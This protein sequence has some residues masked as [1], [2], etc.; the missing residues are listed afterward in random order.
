MC[1]GKFNRKAPTPVTIALGVGVPLVPVPG[2]GLGLGSRPG[3]R[4]FRRLRCCTRAKKICGLENKHL[5]VY[6]LK[7]RRGGWWSGVFLCP[8][9]PVEVAQNL[10]L[11]KVTSWAARPTQ[12]HHPTAGAVP[13]PLG[14][15]QAEPGPCTSLLHSPTTSALLLHRLPLQAQPLG[16]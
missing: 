16:H 7:T 13:A 11:C 6:A 9:S 14:C 5:P 1:F 4:Q 15:V 12:H 10:P 2:R 3:T 8:R